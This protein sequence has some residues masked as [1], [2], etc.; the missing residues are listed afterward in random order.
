MRT[1][2]IAVPMTLIPRMEDILLFMISVG[3]SSR[4]L[5]FEDYFLKVFR[6]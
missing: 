3:D 1:I 5:L 2:A 4:P 6:A